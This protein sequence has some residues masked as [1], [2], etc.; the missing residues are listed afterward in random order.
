MILD[1][2]GPIGVI[3]IR[4]PAGY[5]PKPSQLASDAAVLLKAVDV[6]DAHVLVEGSGEES[7]TTSFR[8][9]QVF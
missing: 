7:E 9:T 2:F 8:N 4:S 3:F 6:G 1:D 5:L